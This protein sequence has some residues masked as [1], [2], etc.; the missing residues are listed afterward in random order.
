M[1]RIL[2]VSNLNEVTTINALVSYIQFMMTQMS[3]PL[4]ISE[5]GIV[6]EGEYMEKVEEM[7]D[8]AL[9]DACTATNPRVPKRSEVIQIYKEIW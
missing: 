5:L 3:I 8:A 9:K 4:K 7:A 1:A 6:S 2:G